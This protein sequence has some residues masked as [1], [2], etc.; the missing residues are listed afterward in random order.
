MHWL[1]HI[2][3]G[4]N[5]GG[6]WY[7]EWSGFIALV[8]EVLPIWAALIVL[9]RKHTCHVDGCHRFITHLDPEVHAP[10]CGLHHSHRGLRGTVPPRVELKDRF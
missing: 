4:D 1:L 6:A 7:L 9:L 8:F 3:G 10:A 5:G 2:T